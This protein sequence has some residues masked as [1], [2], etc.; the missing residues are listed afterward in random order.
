[1]MRC[2]HPAI[3]A[4]FVAA[5]L[6]QAGC[7][8]AAD[9]PEQVAN[10]FL[11]EVS[12]QNCAEAWTYFSRASQEKIRAESAQAIRREPHY[13]DVFKPENL[14]CKSTYANRFISVAPGSAKLQM[15]K[16]TNATVLAQRRE[17]SDVSVPGFVPTKFDKLPMEILLVQ[18]NGLW[19]IDIARPTARDLSRMAQ[20]QKA[21]QREFDLI[22][23]ARATNRP[24]RPL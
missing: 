18:E 21:I 24:P 9:R 12:R 19:K 3:T 17:A 16:G 8:R 23:A 7:R 5:A 22:N 13:A 2:R 6:F 10:K 11:K 15:I 20:R 4:I 1:M 14:Y